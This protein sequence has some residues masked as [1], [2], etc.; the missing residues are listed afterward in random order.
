MLLKCSL[1]ASIILLLLSEGVA[2]AP[3]PVTQINRFQR[4]FFLFRP[5]KGLT[6]T[7]EKRR[8]LGGI[9]AA[10]L[11]FSKRWRLLH[12]LGGSGGAVAVG[13]HLDGDAGGVGHRLSCQVV[14][15]L[16]G[17]RLGG[18]DALNATKGIGIHLEIDDV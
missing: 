3:S 8:N 17:H 12:D 1:S 16:T 9:W 11:F 4:L 18:L 5:C 7:E 13:C 15:A 14:V 6:S 10:P 2:N